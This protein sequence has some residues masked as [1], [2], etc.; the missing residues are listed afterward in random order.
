MGQAKR[1]G[2]FEERKAEAIRRTKPVHKTKVAVMNGCG[3]G[4]GILCALIH[5]LMKDHTVILT[6]KRKK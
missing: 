2:T 1:R 3:Y 6:D 4:K 5:T